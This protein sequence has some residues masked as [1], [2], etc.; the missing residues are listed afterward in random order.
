MKVLCLTVVVAALCSP[1]AAALAP[2]NAVFHALHESIRDLSVY[3]PGYSN[4]VLCF[5]EDYGLTYY[6]EDRIATKGV[7][8]RGTYFP[9]V[10]TLV[11]DDD[12]GPIKTVVDSNYENLTILDRAGFDPAQDYCVDHFQLM[13]TWGHGGSFVSS[14]FII[15]P[16]KVA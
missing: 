7:R 1:F 3:E 9:L 5:I 11:S 4:N 2:P 6:R 13:R 10:V 16:G 12:L 15:R 14:H 8:L